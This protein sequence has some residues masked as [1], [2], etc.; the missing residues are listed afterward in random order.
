MALTTTFGNK[1]A[2]AALIALTLGAG[3]TL[4][5]GDA[6]AR[7]GRKG[8][9]I[10]AGVVGAIAAGALIAGSQRSYAAPGYYADPGY[11]YA[12][13]PTYYQAPA[14]VYYQ[15][16]APVYYQQP[17]QAY[18]GGGQ[19]YHPGYYPQRAR[20]PGYSETGFAYRGPVCKIKKQRYYDGYGYRVQRVR[21]CR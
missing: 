11:D 18:Y 7:Y 15:E 17:T 6:E 14:P 21:V 16:P 8:A 19:V 20:H 10:A 2:A 1:A 13:A 3:L 5:S 12:P 4:N 9:F